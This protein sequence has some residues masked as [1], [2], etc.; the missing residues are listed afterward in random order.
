MVLS[1]QNL[2]VDNKGVDCEKYNIDGSNYFK[3][4]DL[5]YLLKD[6]ASRFGVGYDA[7]SAT[8]T[9][10]A[11]AAY[12]PNGS[13]LVTGTDNSATAQPSSQTILIDGVARGD[14]TVYNIGGNNF[15]Q[16]RELGNVLGFEV[17]YDVGSNTAIVRSVA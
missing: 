6:T 10:T 3:L 17:D 15:F 8:V 14:L 5:A 2:S 13:E 16:L 11:G 4:R 7:A 12:E 1:P 9:I